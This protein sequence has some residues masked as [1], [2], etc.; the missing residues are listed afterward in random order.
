MAETTASPTSTTPAAT[1]AI[2]ARHELPVEMTWDLASVFPDDAAWEQAFGAAEARL[3]EMAAHRG[4]LASSG[5]ALLAALTLRDDLYQAIGRVLVW[6]GRVTL[7]GRLA[8]VRGSVV[9]DAF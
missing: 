1:G 4:R 7:A 3:A 8:T 6:A 9:A 2:P 5:E